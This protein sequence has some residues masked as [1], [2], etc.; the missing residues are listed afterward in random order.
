MVW[1]SSPQPSKVRV[2]KESPMRVH[3]RRLRALSF[4]LLI[5]ASLAG[6]SVAAVTAD[7]GG[8]PWPMAKPAVAAPQDTGGAPWPR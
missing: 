5:S 2:E 8:A 6:T 1:S 7:T 3:A 4:A